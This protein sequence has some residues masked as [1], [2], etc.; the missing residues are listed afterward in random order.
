VR[1]GTGFHPDQINLYVRGEAQKLGTGKPLPHL[2]LSG[3][4]QTNQMKHCLAQ[5]DADRVQVHGNASLPTVIS[6]NGGGPFH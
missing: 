3:L 5:I 1:A 2:N 4:A 6:I